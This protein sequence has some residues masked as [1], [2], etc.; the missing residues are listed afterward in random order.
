L[1]ASDA[2][3]NVLQRETNLAFVSING[4]AIK[5][6]ISHCRGAFDSACHLGSRNVV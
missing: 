4:G 6:P 1:L 3:E 2:S 5:M